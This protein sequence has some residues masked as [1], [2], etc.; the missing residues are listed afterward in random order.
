[1]SETK[2]VEMVAD[3]GEAADIVF[4]DVKAV[5]RGYR[6]SRL[7]GATLL[8]TGVSRSVLLTI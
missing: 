3:I 7:L 2:E 8:T 6:V 4:V 1:M 5:A